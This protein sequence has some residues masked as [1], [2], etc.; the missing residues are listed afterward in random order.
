PD[1]QSQHSNGLKRSLSTESLERALKKA[2]P[3]RNDSPTISIENIPHHLHTV[4]PPPS[5]SITPFTTASSS[6]VAYISSN[7]TPLP[8]IKS[9][10]ISTKTH[11]TEAYRD[12]NDFLS[13]VHR[14]RF[15]DPEERESW[16]T[17]EKDEDE[18]MEE[19][20]HAYYAMNAVLRQ[21]HLQRRNF[22]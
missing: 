14:E 18:K 21:A 5:P 6:N 3:F 9:I 16:W 17:R 10:S 22:R 2:K 7:T 4:Y 13:T 11:P 19:D 1:I 20:H 15:G 8:V 12:M